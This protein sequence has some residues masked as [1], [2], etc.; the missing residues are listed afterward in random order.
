MRFCDFL[1][2]NS[3][4]EWKNIYLNYKMLKKFLSPFKKISKSVIKTSLPQI[5]FPKSENLLLTNIFIED[6]EIL[7]YFCEQFENLLKE[8]FEKIKSFGKFKFHE[9]KSKWKKIKINLIILD[10]Y[11][12]NKNYNEN[13][14]EIKIAIL[15]FYKE[16]L[17][18]TDFIKVNQEGL[19]K[20][21][22][23]AKK[24]GNSLF[25][26]HHIRQNLSKSK[27]YVNLKNNICDFENLKI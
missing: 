24:I 27:E 1:R 25:D 17:L 13:K 23:K 3:V 21:Q 18:L 10:N 26:L 6:V 2:N 5:F 8:E 9:C 11:K 22:K 19:R 7:N 12:F 4:P 20:I 15:K 16:I 14:E